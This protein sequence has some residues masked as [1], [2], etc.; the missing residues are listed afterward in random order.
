[1]QTTH[2]QENP[3]EVKMKLSRIILVIIIFNFLVVN[4][5][6][7]ENLYI[8]F[9]GIGSSKISENGFAEAKTE[10]VD[11]AVNDAFQSAVLSCFDLDL[12]RSDFEAIAVLLEKNNG[13]N[14]VQEYQVLGDFISGSVLHASVSASFSKKELEKLFKESGIMFEKIE[15][16]KIML[17]V[18]EK[19]IEDYDYYQWWKT[20][21]NPRF[22]TTEK[23]IASELEKSGF[24]VN[25]PFV[26]TKI[27]DF[28]F[29]SDVVPDK[30]DAINIALEKNAGIVIVGKS[31]AFPGSNKIQGVDTVKVSLSLIV[32]KTSTGQELC[33]IS[34]DILVK[35]ENGIYRTNEAFERAG[36]EAGAE[37]S[38]KIFSN[39][40]EEVDKKNE[41]TLEI[42]GSNFFLRFISFKN[43]IIN[44]KIIEGFSEKELSSES[45]IS[46][47]SY[48]GT[49]NELAEKIVELPFEGFGVAITDISEKK[50]KIELVSAD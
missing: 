43:K 45:S 32:F 1:L 29:E 38:S 15:L 17:L 12:I 49:A 47:V 35:S 6:S 5:Y 18:S 16:P 27:S 42:S 3:D 13:K 21:E 48:K 36:R 10:A 33:N 41:I 7:K 39:I 40:R 9:S 28:R 4:A 25:Y 46:S 30:K 14:F 2:Y 31:H 24:K 34:K 11:L 19:N 22:G 50:I 8:T 26:Y 44:S 23:G 20:D 37:I